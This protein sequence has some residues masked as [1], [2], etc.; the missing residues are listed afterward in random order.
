MRC[1]RCAGEVFPTD[2]RASFHGL[3]AAFGKAG[4]AVACAVFTRIDT[5]DTFYASA[6]TCAWGRLSCARLVS[7][8]F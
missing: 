6:F 3:S 5:R 8:V 2:V 7:F 1:A 4:A